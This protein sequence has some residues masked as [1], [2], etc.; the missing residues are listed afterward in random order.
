MLD[1][2]RNGKT[3]MAAMA[4]KGVMIGRTWPIWPSRVRITVGTPAEMDRFQHAYQQVMQS[5]EEA[6]LESIPADFRH[7]D[8]REGFVS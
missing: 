6:L 2:K 1:T 7:P 5:T 3:V 4:A 8:W